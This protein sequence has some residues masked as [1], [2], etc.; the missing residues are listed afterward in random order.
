MRRTTPTSRSGLTDGLALNY[1]RDNP[2]DDFYIPPDDPEQTPRYSAV[3]ISPGEPGYTGDI[4]VF[5]SADVTSNARGI[6]VGHYG[7]SGAL[8]MELTGGNFT[9]M[10]ERAFA[11]HMLS[12]KRR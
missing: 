6:S 10:G 12:W 5:S 1:D 3:W 7:E 2:G 9:T 8:R 4:S 11:I